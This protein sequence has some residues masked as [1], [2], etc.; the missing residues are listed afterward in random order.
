MVI[1]G[2]KIKIL[3]FFLAHEPA[4]RSF[5]GKGR[6]RQQHREGEQLSERLQESRNATDVDLPSF[7]SPFVVGRA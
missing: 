6:Y 2:L 4:S 5:C 7:L 1:G 3:F